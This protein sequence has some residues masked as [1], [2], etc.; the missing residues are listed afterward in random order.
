ML[1]V[2]FV[3][4]F[5][6]V[7]TGLGWSPVSWL[8]AKRRLSDG[9]RLVVA[10]AVGCFV[11]YLGVFAIGPLRLDALSMWGLAAACL[12]AAVPGLRRMEWRSFSAALRSEARDAR[13]E[14]WRAFLWLVAAVVGLSALLQGMAPPNDYDSLMYHLS[15]PLYDI[16]RGYVDI[17]WD[18]R[19]A[20]VAF[21]P[22]LMENLS[23]FA[24]AVM[25][26][27]VA[28][29][30]HG[31]FGFVAAAGTALLLR[32]VGLSKTVALLGAVLFLVCRVV[33]WEMAT[34][35]TDVP[36]AAYAVLALVVYLA[37][38]EDHGVGLGV[39]FGMMV[40]GAILTKYIGFLVALSFGPL[41]IYDFAVRRRAW[42]R[43]LVGPLAALVTISPH[44]IH[45]FLY[46][47][48]PIFPLFNPLF[49]PGGPAFMTNVPEWGGTGRGIVDLIA[50][51][52]NVFVVPMHY[53]DGMV[54][55]APYLL[56]L[57][58]LILLD[59]Q[60]L[61]RWGPP[62]ATLPVAYLLWFYSLSQAVRLLLPLV[63]VLAAAAAA[64]AAALWQEL[65]GRRLLR[66][67]LVAVAAVMA[68]NQA[69]FVGVYAGIRLPAAVGLMDDATYHART[70][71]LTGA[72]YKTCT[73]IRDNLKEGERYYSN[74]IFH[75][76]YCPQ[77]AATY[78]Y[79]ADEAQWW[80]DSETPPE[81]S[82][83]EFLRRAEEADFKYFLLTTGYVTRRNVTARP[84]VIPTDL[85]RIR[86]GAYLQPVFE[87]LRPLSEGP[88]SAVYDGAE[89]LELLRAE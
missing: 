66:T 79:F 33:I 59:R 34:P 75:S 53:F 67:A 61:A 30:L 50:T 52:W 16:E 60:R 2:L 89:V 14:P 42:F 21:F 84:E 73:Y 87:K 78:I 24:L 44:L 28:Q 69:M 65:R 10:F 41:L 58:P 11:V 63:P 49:N 18:R 19:A 68:A 15:F 25:N 39:L 47:G 62:L 72:F 23:R 22:V 85:S 20:F 5:A 56:A 3:V 4:A 17:A 76:Y 35:E 36:L 77:V 83:R 13:G 12:A 29:M 8:D 1:S 26:D 31:L 43:G 54:F 80:L 57:A 71:T 45:N 37:W 46:T 64:G 40:G 51:P 38:R 48:N 88:Y 6:V 27:G 70:P 86:F 82:H 9:E 74:I 55:G 7:V 81:M 32:R